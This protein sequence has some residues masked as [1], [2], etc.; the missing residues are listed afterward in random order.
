M[1]RQFIC[2]VISIVVYILFS[3]IPEELLVMPVTPTTRVIAFVP[4]IL[5]IMWGLAG[6]LGVAFANLVVLTVIPIDLPL[7]LIVRDTLAIFATAYIP[8]RLWFKTFIN[9]DEPLFQ[10]SLHV[11]LKFLVLLSI[12]MF[13][14]SMIFGLTATTMELNRVFLRFGDELDISEYTFIHFINDIDVSMFMAPPVFLILIGLGFR[15]ERPQGEITYN[16]LPDPS[17]LKSSDYRELILLIAGL[18]VFFWIVFTFLGFSGMLKGLNSLKTW[19]MFLTRVLTPME[20]TYLAFLS[21]L[22]KYKNSIMNEFIMLS[23]GIVFSASTI[24]GNIG[25]MTVEDIMDKRSHEDL[26]QLATIQIEHLLRVFDNVEIS[27]K[28][29][30][31]FTKDDSVDKN[32][33]LTDEAYRKNFVDNLEKISMAIAENTKGI[34]AFYMRFGDEVLPV[35]DGFFWVLKGKNR[36]RNKNIF[37][38][39]PLTPL[40]QYSPDDI[41][42]VGWYYIPAET[43]RPTWTPPYFNKNAGIYMIS[44]V[45]PIYDNGR[46]LYVVGMDIDMNYIIDEVKTLSMYNSGQTY[47]MD[48]QGRAIYHPDY[49]VGTKIPDVVYS[50]VVEMGLRNGITL[51][52]ASSAEDIEKDRNDLAVRLIFA[53]L[54]V[55]IILSLISIRISSG[56][57]QPLLQVN[58]AAKK[59]ADGHLEVVIDYNSQNEL[60]SMVQS[61]H[62]MVKKLDGYMYRDKMTGM[63]NNSAYILA[64]KILNDR[65]AAGEDFT[66][67]VIVFD[68]NSLKYVNDNYGHDAGNE[69]IRRAVEMINTVFNYLPTYRTGGDEFVTIIEDADYESCDEMLDAFAERAK[70]EFIQLG[71]EQFH[72]SVAYGLGIYIPGEDESFKEVFKRADDEMYV[73]KQIIKRDLNLPSR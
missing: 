36:I 14:G 52:I 50:Q 15:F 18:T 64:V 39:Q 9:K 27:V 67:G 6:S 42:R 19:E 32:R 44:Y 51:A 10:L 20:L 58:E 33:L 72:V 4:P 17:V 43:G 31:D 66:F 65:I 41:E 30:Q 23:V 47:L 16:I 35:D 5:G 13:A 34:A 29:M 37:E 3:L 8:H 25:I 57:I 49:P 46:L 48:T 56:I 59:I 61:I 54:L 70:S 26:Q 1:Q 7:D 22:L 69:L 11:L 68:V 40:H 73:N 63:K 53:A 55:S 45:I 62:E 71:D 21:L 38:K 24:I 60:G 12:G 2:F 28:N